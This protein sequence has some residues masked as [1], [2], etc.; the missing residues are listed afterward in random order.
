MATG[1]RCPNKKCRS[2]RIWKKGRTPT[3]HGER[4]RYVCFTCG[5]TFYASDETK[6][7]TEPKKKGK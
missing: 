1:M 5:R 3:R 2:T 6:V 4:Q 7:K